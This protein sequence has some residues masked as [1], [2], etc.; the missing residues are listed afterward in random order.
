MHVG[1]FLGE[2]W[3]TDV[4]SNPDT[5]QALVNAVLQSDKTVLAARRRRV[6]YEKAMENAIENYAAADV[7]RFNATR[8]ILTVPTLPGYELPK[9]DFEE[10]ICT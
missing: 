7:Q 6:G 4:T 9:Y 10:V 1:N 5:R 3:S 2:E 8:L